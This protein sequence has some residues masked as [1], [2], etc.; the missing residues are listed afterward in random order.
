LIAIS[1]YIKKEGRVG[2]CS[3]GIEYMPSVFKALGLISSTKKTEKV[4]MTKKQ[5]CFLNN[6]K[7]TK[8]SSKLAER[9]K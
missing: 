8:L 6:C 3:S 2:G 4:N 5:Q 9:R 1:A 7:N